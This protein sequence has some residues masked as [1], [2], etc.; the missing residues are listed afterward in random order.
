M[1]IATVRLSGVVRW[2]AIASLVLTGLSCSD[3]SGAPTGP[4]D[5]V[6]IPDL[7]LPQ[8]DHDGLVV[9]EPVGA[10]E[11][12]QSSN[13]VSFSMLSFEGSALSYVSFAPGTHPAEDSVEI[14]N[15]TEGISVGARLVDGGLDPIAIPAS[16]GDTLVIT[17]FRN[18]AGREAR[19]HEVPARKPPVVVR[20]DPPSKKTRVPLNAVIVIVFSEPVDETTV[21]QSSV[22]LL[23]DFG[24]VPAG[25]N[26]SADEMRLE[27]RPQE[28]LK[29]SQTYTIVVEPTVSDLN[30]DSLNEKFTS[31]FTTVD[32]GPTRTVE[33]WNGQIALLS[34]RAAEAG[35]FDLGPWQIYLAENSA[36]EFLQ[37]DTLAVETPY[38]YRIGPQLS[39]DGERIAFLHYGDI[40]LVDAAG[41]D[42]V[43][44]TS[45]GD[46]NSPPEWAPDSERIVYTAGVDAQ[47]VRI[48]AVDGSGPPIEVGAGT[49]NPAWSPDGSYIAFDS[50]SE[51][52]AVV[53]PDGSDLTLVGI[54]GPSWKYPRW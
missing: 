22:R 49:G 30:G 41:G 13:S 46:V 5:P 8:L 45:S 7:G 9:T 23:N 32:E 36:R 31:V 19:A 53:R 27:V 43:N 47:T 40:W 21:N 16:V 42:L 3:D 38:P 18:G 2:M 48:L 24:V 14:R 1:K 33:S 29:S 37:V 6:G 52:I 34:N 28:D 54:H 50:P 15:W 51:Q 44:L 20:T 17:T 10:D 35:G 4:Q 39:P 25:F 11:A 12:P 26:L